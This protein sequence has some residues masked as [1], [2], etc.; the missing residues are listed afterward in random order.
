MMISQL[1]TPFKIIIIFRN[2]AS[3]KYLSFMFHRRMKLRFVI[4]QGRVYLLYC[5]FKKRPTESCVERKAVVY[6]LYYQTMEGE[7]ELSIFTKQG[8]GS[9]LIL[10]AVRKPYQSWLINH[11]CFPHHQTQ[12][13]RPPDHN[14]FS[15]FSPQSYPNFLSTIPL[16]MN[17]V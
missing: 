1:M 8:T 13:L 12:Q 16:V 5:L 14:V 6:Q 7:S 3:L 17:E 2:V 4:T 15:I 10:P 11:F 9:G